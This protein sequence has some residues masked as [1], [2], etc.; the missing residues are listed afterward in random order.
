MNRRRFVQGAAVATGA[1]A[2][3]GF[4]AWKFMLHHLEVVDVTL[5][6]AGLPV[7]LEGARMVQVSD[8]H[9]GPVVDDAYVMR[10]LALAGSLAPDILVFTGDFVTWHGPEQ[11]AQLDRVLAAKP[12]PRLATVAV[13]GN[14]DYGFGWREQ[15]VASRVIDIVKRHGVTVIRNDVHVVEGLAFLGVDDMWAGMT[16]IPHARQAL[17]SG[18]PSIALCHNPD[19]ADSPAWQGYRGWMLSGHTHG[20][21]CRA[22]FCAPPVLPVQNRRYAAGE[23]ALG[24]GRTLY[25][26]RG[27]GHTLPVRV[28]VRPEVT[29]YRLVRA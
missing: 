5:P 2:V 6:V 15:S 22:P 13:L 12:V 8:L 23:V 19:A 28:L 3:G 21:Q 20:G 25:V 1:A 4:G 9:I 7:S 24:S 14:H 10:A 17:A 16:D 18:M 27:I 11:L 26:N 29:S